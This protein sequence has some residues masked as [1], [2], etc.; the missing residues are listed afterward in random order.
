MNGNDAA[1]ATAELR[2][3]VEGIEGR[4]DD[5]AAATTRWLNDAG[6]LSGSAIDKF[7]RPTVSDMLLAPGS[8]VTG[9]GFIASAGLL[10]PDR[11][12]I[13]WWQGEDLERV[14]ALANFSP[15]SM[16]R[17]V[18]AEWFKVPV[19][20]RRPH[21]TGPYIDLLCTDEYVLTFTHP[22]F[23]GDAVAGIV[24]LDVTAQTLERRALPLLRRIGPRAALV[25]AGGRTIVCAAPDVDAGDVIGPAEGAAATPIGR[26][27]TLLAAAAVA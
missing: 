27:F 4:I 3:L 16:S 15:Q 22:V 24:G 26:S 10:G 8:N 25:S 19:A 17:Y 21:V 23:R 2:T 13:A 12:Y 7:V 5:W 14:D 1:P 6:K 11:S 9:A 20:T 18:G